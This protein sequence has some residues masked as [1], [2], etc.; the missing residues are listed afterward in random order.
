MSTTV[1]AFAALERGAKITPWSYQQRDVRPHDVRID[2]LYCGVCHTDLHHIGPWGRHFPVVPGHE[3]VGRV[4][5]IGPEVTTHARG[6]LVAVGPIVDSCR[7]CPPCLAGDETLCLT[8]ATA[9]Y[10]AEDRHGDGVTRGGWADRVV[11]DERYVYRLPDGLDPA[12]AAPLLCAG[13]TVFAPLRHWGAGPGTTVG[14]V[15]I[16]GLGHLGLKFARAMGA[17]VT[18]FTTSAAKAAD[19]RRLG[20]HDVVLAGDPEQPRNRFDLIIDTVP[21]VHP[22]TPLV[23]ALKTDGTLVTVGLPGTLDVAPFA[24]AVGRK[25]IA[26]AGAGGT[27]DTREMLEFAATHGITADIELIGTADIDRALERLAANDIKYRFVIDLKR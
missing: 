14:I 7:T 5:E 17:H 19:A 4:T 1:N 12:S 8:I 11:T 13:S 3:L 2:V 15:G 24:M 16:G 23:Q 27:R 10:G 25:S 18:A 26:G 20:A 21:A 6:D 22:M 9:T